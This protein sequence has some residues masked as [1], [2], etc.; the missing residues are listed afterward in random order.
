MSFG[1]FFSDVWA[2]LLGQRKEVKQTTKVSPMGLV[3]RGVNCSD[4]PNQPDV[5]PLAMCMALLGFFRVAGQR[6][7]G[8]LR[9][10]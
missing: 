7:T 5:S 3:F 6:K 4:F 1:L 10:G 9:D 8:R 2:N